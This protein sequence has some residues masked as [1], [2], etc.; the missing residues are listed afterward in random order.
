MLPYRLTLPRFHGSRT[1][2]PGRGAGVALVGVA[3][4]TG[5]AG[6]WR[7]VRRVQVVG[8]SMEP[9]L[10][11]GDRL[12]VVRRPGR[13]QPWPRPGDVVAVRDPRL[14]SRI[15]IKRVSAVDR[16][17][18]TV[19]VR[20]DAPDASTDSRDFGPLAR[21]A[22]VGR[23]VYRYGPAGRN[24]PGPWPGEYHRR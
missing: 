1:C 24:G 18:G 5:A 11:A 19:D 2:R 4:L 3:A 22:V 23:A 7:C 21:S 10:R 16:R 6:L 15:L 13:T 9:A 17:Q 14:P 20:G 12:V 8:P